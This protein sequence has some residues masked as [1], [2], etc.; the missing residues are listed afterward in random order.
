VKPGPEIE[1][2]GDS[3][4]NSD[5][6]RLLTRCDASLYGLT[7]NGFAGAGLL[8]GGAASDCNH[9]GDLG[10]LREVRNNS[11]GGNGRGIVISMTP[12]NR[13]FWRDTVIEDN[14]ISGNRFT[15]I[16]VDRGDA[17]VIEKNKVLENGRSG[18]YLGTVNFSDVYDNVI[19]GNA[20]FG[21]AMERQAHV[22]MA[23]NSIANN[24]LT[25][26]DVGLDLVTSNVADDSGRAPNAPVL[27]SA[28]FDPVTGKTIV[29]GRADSSRLGSGGAFPQWFV[30]L[31]ASD[32]LNPRGLPQSERP[33]SFG[34][35]IMDGHA[36]F[37]V[38]IADDLSG[39]FI[40]ATLTRSV[41]I[42]FAK[43][44]GEL[45]HDDFYQAETSE[46]SN[47]VSVDR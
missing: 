27:V 25:A 8:I 30:S 42:G 36:D 47:A 40:T 29:R 21:I 45:S 44:V 28:K 11:I 37:E 3:L 10:A 38:A 31:Y 20:E 33:L 22:Y 1:L 16:F 4:A 9:D 14:I 46:L 13:F 18:I 24:G 23:G 17:L 34:A 15:G 35:A 41:Y 12:V 43:P 32:S 7:V 5:G 26:I 2:L 19:D 6:L 39:K